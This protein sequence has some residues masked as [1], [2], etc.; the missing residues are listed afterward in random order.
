MLRLGSWPVIIFFSFLFLA[1]TALGSAAP[2][3]I[4]V[5]RN[6]IWF[7]V[8]LPHIPEQYLED[9]TMIANYLP[10]IVNIFLLYLKKKKKK[11]GDVLTN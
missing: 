6:S 4:K 9:P 8:R 3:N 2:E 10:L 11:K 1:G 7:D 5:I